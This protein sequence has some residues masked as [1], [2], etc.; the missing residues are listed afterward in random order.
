MSLGYP[1]LLDEFN[2]KNQAPALKLF[3]LGTP[4][5]DNKQNYSL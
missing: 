5:I 4:K 2:L 3:K 1:F